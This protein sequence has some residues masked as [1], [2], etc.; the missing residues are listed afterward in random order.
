M[1]EQRGGPRAVM[2]TSETTRCLPG[3]AL[4]RLVFGELQFPKSFPKLEP[5]W[6][7]KVFPTIV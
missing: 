6:W 2:L 3:N 5:R 4:L 7:G 1:D